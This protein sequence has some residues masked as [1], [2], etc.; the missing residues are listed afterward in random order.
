M[1]RQNLN[2]VWE[3]HKN[4]QTITQYLG[5]ALTAGGESATAALPEPVALKA[6]PKAPTVVTR[7]GAGKDRDMYGKKLGKTHANALLK[8]NKSA[9]LTDADR[10]LRSLLERDDGREAFRSFL[11]AEY[12]D[13]ALEF[14][15]AAQELGGV[16]SGE[17]SAEA[18]RLMDKYLGTKDS[19]GGMGKQD[20]TR[21]TSK[22]WDGAKGRR[23]KTR[24]DPV[25]LVAKEAENTFKMFVVD[26]FP[27]FVKSK[28]ARKL[29]KHGLALILP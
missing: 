4:D 16:S 1:A 11:K 12:N 13:A 23:V 3:S 14:W 22:L 19:S 6:E 10:S 24:R 5:E 17:Q 8:M 25:M 29:G 18:Q 26:T 28:Q 21:A 15:L 7:T 2:A 27:R 9:W 20:R